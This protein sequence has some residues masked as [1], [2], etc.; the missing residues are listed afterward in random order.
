MCADSNVV[1]YCVPPQLVSQIWPTV[2]ER[3]HTAMQRGG[4][5][6]FNVLMADVL[7]GRALLWVAAQDD[8][9]VTAA[10]TQ[11]GIGVGGKVCEIVACGGIDTLHHLHLLGEIEDYARNEDCR[12][13]RIIGR[14]G[15]IRML[16][17]YRA[18]RVVLEKELK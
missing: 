4:L 2:S 7:S 1:A 8:E 18:T 10:V 12:A 3:L 17:D 6:S 5:G 16:P 13:T 11:I 15:W 9:I 14:K